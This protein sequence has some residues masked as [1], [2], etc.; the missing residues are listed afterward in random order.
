MG[1]G[2][3]PVPTRAL[4]KIYAIARRAAC[5]EKYRQQLDPETGEVTGEFKNLED[6]F[7]KVRTYFDLDEPLDKWPPGFR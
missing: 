7:E 6:A 1:P 3:P 5:E 4:Q 2:K